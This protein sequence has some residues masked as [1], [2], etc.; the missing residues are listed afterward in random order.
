[1]NYRKRNNMNRSIKKNVILNVIRQ[2]CSIVFPLIIFPYISRVLGPENYGK[3]SFIL[4]IVNYFTL[5]A[6]LGINTYAIREGARIRNNKDYLNKFASEITTINFISMVIS[7]IVLGIL[8][9]IYSKLY[10]YKELLLILS[11]II[12]CTMLGRDWINN[13]FEDFLY[14]TV[15]YVLLQ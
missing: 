10:E 2:G 14:I 3:Y 11:F 1:K 12:P 9:I 15:R 4:S 5:F 8:T 7:I 13:I 6:M